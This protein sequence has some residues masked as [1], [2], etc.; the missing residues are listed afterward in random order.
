MIYPEHESKTL[1]FK[2]KLPKLQKLVKTCVAFANAYGGKILI[3]IEDDG[4]IVGVSDAVRN[5][6]YDEFPNSLYDSTSPGLLAE[7]YEKRI[8]EKSILIIEIPSSIKKPVFLKEEGLP[9][10][11]YLRAGSNTRRAT[12]TYV[13][14]L[15]RENKRLN[16]DEEVVQVSP[17]KLSKALLKQIFGR[18]DNR[19]LVAE[20]VLAQSTANSQTYY[21]TVAGTLCFCEEP[22]KYISEAIVL[23]TKFKGVSGR[24]IIN[25]ITIQGTLETQ[26]E[27][28]F[29]L[30]SQWLI[31][32]YKLVGVKLKPKTIIPEE[33][34]REAIIN[35]LLHRKY[36]IPGAVKVAMYDDRLE[37]FNPG[38]FPGLVDLN[39]L[40]DGTTYLRN[41]HLAKLARRFG[42]VEKLGTGIRLMKESCKASRVMPPKFIEGADSVKVIFYFLPDKNQSEPEE[43]ILLALFNARSEV[44]V[45]EVEKYLGVSRNTATRKLAVL[46]KENKIRRIGKG[47]SVRYVKVEE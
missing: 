42:L 13:E 45:G 11:V 22:E 12:E 28:T 41:P 10:G 1:E 23:C 16:F 26:A 33:A 32:G 2:S 6:V 25:T 7:I 44:T 29:K 24:E 37:I 47:P 15:M 20:K 4:S 36:W 40:G 38:S 35:A 30:V 18:Y 9:K 43:D 5:R 46:I 19:R 34:F 27:E 21:P 39:N 17:D 8:G 14:D 31:E 3:G